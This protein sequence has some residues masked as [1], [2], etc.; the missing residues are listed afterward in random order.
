MLSVLG[1]AK[2]G[3]E[4]RT[5]GCV[6]AT[7]ILAEGSGYVP[8]ATMCLE[9]PDPY[10]VPDRLC[11]EAEHHH[12]TLSSLRN[13]VD[14]SQKKSLLLPIVSKSFSGLGFPDFPECRV[15]GPT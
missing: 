12:S 8:N 4:T 3:H 5:R 14:L 1:R 13:V 2:T 10:G 7:G 11:P 15:S 6:F 9:Q